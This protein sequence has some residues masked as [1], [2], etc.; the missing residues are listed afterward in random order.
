MAFP[1]C[2]FPA[3]LDAI[4][5][6]DLALKAPTRQ[7]EALHPLDRLFHQPIEFPRAQLNDQLVDL[8]I[9][10]VHD[11]IVLF[12][13]LNCLLII[14]K[15]AKLCSLDLGPK[16]VRGDNDPSNVSL[17]LCDHVPRETLLTA[18]AHAPK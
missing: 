15:T 13:L 12:Q 6:D 14:Q 3:S 10:M 4:P 5:Q 9:I 11:A 7:F 2:P 1:S 18:N 17:A 8:R 16:F